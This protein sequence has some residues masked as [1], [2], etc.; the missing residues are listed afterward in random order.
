MTIEK[1]NSAL[2]VSTKIDTLSDYT[3]QNKGSAK[4][5]RFNRYEIDALYSGTGLSRKYIR[6]YTNIDLAGLQFTFG[7][8]NKKTWKDR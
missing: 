7:D 2:P 5:G 3:L 4:S 6:D 8:L 1:I